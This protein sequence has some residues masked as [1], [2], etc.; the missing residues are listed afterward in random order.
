MK[1]DR[2]SVLLFAGLAVVVGIA[3]TD[4]ARHTA[5]PSLPAASAPAAPL[6]P[7]PDGFEQAKLGMPLDQVRARYPQLKPMPPNA[8][9]ATFK[10]PFLE[11]YMLEDVPVAGLAAPVFVELRFWKNELWSIVVYCAPNLL[12]E[13][14]DYFTQ[15]FGRPTTE[16]YN[17]TWV[18]AKSTVTMVSSELWYSITD[19]ALNVE[20]RQEFL[21]AIRALGGAPAPP[22]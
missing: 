13:V 19:N 16:G 2:R 14:G 10:S 3:L 17:P 8:G 11:R 6:L 21:R 22:Q 15:H 7:G 20:V 18:F 9:A 1:N 5:P 12:P 4:L